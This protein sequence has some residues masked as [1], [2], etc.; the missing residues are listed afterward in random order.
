MTSDSTPARSQRD[1]SNRT[2]EQLRSLAQLGDVR[3]AS[4]RVHEALELFQRSLALGQELVASDVNNNDW[5]RDLAASQNRVGD[6][7]KVLGNLTGALNA[8]TAGLK[9]S[10]ALSARDP[11]NAQWQR[12]ISV[13]LGSG[14]FGWRKVICR[15]RWRPTSEDST[16][17]MI[18]RHAIRGMP[19]GSAT[20][21]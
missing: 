18:W 1:E 7:N 16:L 21:R 17:P 12:D 10:E 11:A 20:Y 9:L 2:A 3:L 4:G 8:Y 13:S 6:A 19:D 14:T 15:E 5:Q